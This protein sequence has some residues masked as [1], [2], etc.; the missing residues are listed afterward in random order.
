MPR[1]NRR[2]ARRAPLALPSVLVLALAGAACAP[3]RPARLSPEDREGIRALEGAYTSAW[4]AND[5]AAVMATLAAG[6]VIVPGGVGAIEGEAAIR[7]FWWP[8]D[9]P[10]TTV[11]SYTTTIDEIGG[12]GSVAYLR[13][14][15]ELTFTWESPDGTGGER[16]SRS[17][18]LAVVRKGPDGAWKIARRMWSNL[19]G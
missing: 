19:S 4:M 15:G 18:F 3:D 2:T 5:S 10:T 6:A 16:T 11:T 1:P 17:V 7:D 9:G 13:G 14:R 8:E 12:S